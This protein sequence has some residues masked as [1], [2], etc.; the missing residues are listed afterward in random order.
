M[1]GTLLFPLLLAA[2]DCP[3]VQWNVQQD[4][5]T[6]DWVQHI[7]A[8]DWNQDGTPDITG[9][10]GQG[11]DT[12]LMWWRGLGDGTFGAPAAIMK[13][14]SLWGFA[15]AD[16]NGD[17]R[18]DFLIGSET[19]YIPGNATGRGKA[20]HIPALVG[21]DPS[22]M[23]AGNFDGDPAIELVVS[24]VNA[25]AIVLL[26]NTAGNLTELTRIPVD[27]WPIGIRSA[28]FDGDGRFDLAVAMQQA[29]AVDVYFKNANGVYAAPV[30]LPT[31][32]ET[33]ELLS[34]DVDG[35]GRPD[36]VATALNDGTVHIFRANANRTF[37]TS[38]LTNDRPGEST[39]N[40]ALALA[41]IS[42]DGKLDL[43]AGSHSG[44]TTTWTGTG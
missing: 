44:W 15:V 11:A 9:V 27:S 21:L 23:H 43:I 38:T 28:D 37:A 31:G 42:G 40:S 19:Q 3:S 16:F 8:I 35:D 36:L 39:T 4:V 41:D 18:E 14:A 6:T 30:S 24:S 7:Q 12:T 20:V 10:V 26:D 33:R 25:S 1:L 13:D 17:G 32:A 29:H 22:A 5:T 34:G 2:T